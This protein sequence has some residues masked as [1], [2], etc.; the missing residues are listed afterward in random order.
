[1]NYMRGFGLSLFPP[2]IKGL[3]ITNVIVFLLQHVMGVFNFGGVSLQD[4]IYYFGALFPLGDHSNFQ[5]WQLI[6]YQF[7]HGDFFHIL[8]NLWMLWIFG[9][10]L[11]NIWGTKRFLVF[12]LLCGIGA[13]LTQLYI[14]PMLT[15]VGPTV[16]ASGSVYGVLL[17]F[18]LSFPDRPI[19]V[20]PL[21]FPIKAIYMVLGLTAIELV[22]GI[23]SSGAG[24][25]HFAHLGGA[26]TGFII[27]QVWKRQNNPQKFNP[28]KNKFHSNSGW[29][30]E[31]SGATI[32]SFNSAGSASQGGITNYTS[33][34]LTV[35]GE[36]ITQNKIDEILDKISSTGYNNLSEREKKILFELS[37]K[38]K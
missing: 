28:F 5:I 10:E 24:I 14:S 9:V 32:H 37:Q 2:A 38:L 13:G 4:I 23:T 15:T 34:S 31:P 27:L 11:E 22:M 16:G 8:F 6:S 12:Y 19:M 36:Q 18:A 30:A 17:A 7:L 35:D 21:F 1:M 29:S 25:A 33:G 3:L 26:L 20:F